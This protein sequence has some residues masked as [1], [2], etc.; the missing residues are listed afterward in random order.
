[1]SSK[2]YLFH[3]DTNLAFCPITHFLALAFA[4]EAFAAPDLVSPEQLFKLN[5]IAGL[6]EQPLPWKKSMRN[7]PLFR[8]SV[9]TKDG[10]QI[11][12]DQALPY[13]TYHPSLTRLGFATGFSEITT[14]YCLRRAT[15]NAVNG[16]NLHISRQQNLKTDPVLT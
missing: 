4:D 6:N 2:I 3:E 8:R 1:M 13:S 9:R 7:I 12:P 10:V 15:A 5:V 11:L 14:T 16:I